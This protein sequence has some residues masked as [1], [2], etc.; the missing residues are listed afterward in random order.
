MNIL[1]HAPRIATPPHL[2]FSALSTTLAVKNLSSP[3]FIH[4]TITKVVRT[5][6]RIIFCYRYVFAKN[7]TFSGVS[8]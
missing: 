3:L 7:P 6:S 2:D 1:P 5:L 4:N 8:Q